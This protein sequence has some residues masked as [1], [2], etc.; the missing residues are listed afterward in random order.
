MHNFYYMWNQED[1]SARSG[2]MNTSQL[3]HGNG[4]VADLVITLLSINSRNDPY[5]GGYKF[6]QGF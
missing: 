6:D 2:M 1:K 4:S 3:S 5:G